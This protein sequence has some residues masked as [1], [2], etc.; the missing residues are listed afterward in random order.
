MDCKEYNLAGALASADSKYLET[1]D[2]RPLNAISCLSTVSCRIP[3]AAE[4][5]AA[6]L[7]I[8]GFTFAR[9]QCNE[10]GI[11]VS[12]GISQLQKAS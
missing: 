9:V 8:S 1:T 3:G 10:S 4:P 7:A 12:F 6:T 5:L 11:Y 2:E